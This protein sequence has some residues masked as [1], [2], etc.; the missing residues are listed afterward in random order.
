MRGMK[1][2]GE[3]DPRSSGDLG[4]GLTRRAVLRLLAGATA[5]AGFPFGISRLSAGSAPAV[6]TSSYGF[7]SARELAILDAATAHI[8]P[9][10]DRPGAREIGVVDYIQSLLSF[11]PG[12]DANC[13]RRVDAADVTA[14]WRQAAGEPALCAPGG[15]VNGDAVVDGEDVKA[16]EAAAFRAR[17]VFAGGPFSGRNPQPHFPIGST[18][19]AVCHAAGGGGAAAGAAQATVDVYPPDAF[20]EFLPLTRLQRLSWKVR[21]LGAEAVPE[22]AENPLAASLPDVALR[23]AYRDGL[24]ALDDTSRTEFGLS[25][26]ELDAEQRTQVLNE[27]PIFRNLLTRHVIEGT[28][29]APEYGGNRDRLGWQLVRFDGDS[30][31]LGYEIYDASVE[32]CYRERPDK[33]NSGPNPDEDCSGFSPNLRHFLDLISRATGGRRFSDPYCLGVGA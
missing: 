14:V 16:A 10:D 8:L 22:V 17:P 27:A 25:F 19:C 28:L 7:L 12:A 13:D 29:C 2:S 21:L 1:L 5:A 18:P 9:T 4:P 11:L 23:R 33:P 6:S 3:A 24:A 20:R 15:D 32:G 31:P 30:Q 26:V